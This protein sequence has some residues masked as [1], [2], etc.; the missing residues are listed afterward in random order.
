MEEKPRLSKPDGLIYNI[1]Q[2]KK[3]TPSSGVLF[4]IA[5][6]SFYFPP[7]FLT[8]GLPQ[9]LPCLDWE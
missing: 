8:R 5:V 4:F 7:A 6:D 3:S 1:T 2:N 9:W